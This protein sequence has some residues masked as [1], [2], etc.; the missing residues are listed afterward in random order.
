MRQYGEV[1]PWL[2]AL[3]TP[4]VSAVSGLGAGGSAAV[5]TEDSGGFGNVM[6]TVGTGFSTTWSVAITFPSAPPT[7]F[8]SGDDDFGPISQATVGNVVTLSGTQATFR[9]L[10]KPYTLHYEW[11]TSN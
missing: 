9:L 10:G 2:A 4:K 6:V 11:S 1:P 7:L 5:Q 3:N 8:V